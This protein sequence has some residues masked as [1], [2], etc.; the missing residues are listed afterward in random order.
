MKPRYG[1]RHG[2]HTTRI[3][4]YGKFL[5]IKDTIGLRYVNKKL[6]KE[7]YMYANMIIYSSEE[8]NLRV[9]LELTL[10]SNS[11]R[12]FFKQHNH[13][14]ITTSEMRKENRT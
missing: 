4:R 12:H 10:S 14:I 3:Q 11:C 9:A 7:L 6:L 5:K 8:A 2:Y 13:T 1:I